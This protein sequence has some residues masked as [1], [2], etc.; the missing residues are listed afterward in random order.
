[1]ASA[2]DQDLLE[3]YD[4]DDD[5]LDYDADSF[6]IDPNVKADP[7]A[8]YDEFD[9]DEGLDDLEKDLLDNS[10]ESPH[11]DDSDRPYPSPSKDPS[12]KH[13]SS[14]TNGDNVDNKSLTSVKNQPDNEGSTSTAEGSS[15]LQQSSFNRQTNT[16]TGRSPFTNS[17]GSGT[18]G[19][20]GYTQGQRGGYLGMN[21]GGGG[22]GNSGGIN[23][24]RGNFQGGGMGNMP[25]MGNMGR[26]G[27]GMGMGMGMNMN[28]NMTPA[29]LQN[30]GM[31]MGM[32]M[33]NM[34]MAMMNMSGMG[35]GRGNQFSAGGFSNQ[36]GM[37]MFGQGQGMNN[38]QGGRGSPGSVGA[39]GR[40]IHINPNFQKNLAAASGTNGAAQSQQF[41]NQQQQQFQ[42]HG[43]GRGTTQNWSQNQKQGNSMNSSAGRS[44]FGRSNGG[45]SSDRDG[46]N[47]DRDQDGS[48]YISDN[49][50]GSDAG[51]RGASV[52]LDRPLGSR[53]SRSPS[54]SITS[55]LSLGTK[56]ANDGPEESH[57]ALKSS[58]GS[59]PRGEQNQQQAVDSSPENGSVSFLREKRFA[60][61][62]DERAKNSNTNNGH[63]NVKVEPKGHV[64]MENIPESVS[65]DSL[66]KLANGIPGVDRVLT[67]TRKGDRA[68]VLGFASVEEA[69]FFRRQINRT[70]IEGSLVT[71]TLA[72]A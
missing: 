45:P 12:A 71:V 33:N 69:K 60:T 9:L 39:M 49:R 4:G 50:R 19:R 66:R 18:N 37:G 46:Y 10:N 53:R 57:K 2:K 72:S 20:G 67:I 42:G 58:G 15:S 55:R 52:N 22:R 1:M 43:Q 63:S 35:M 44:G 21:G 6:E 47:S 62:R 68:V 25:T 16:T 14:P 26:G 24:G 5:L 27:M 61:D 32:N 41:P 40:N 64:K 56:R 29:M 28:M 70:T 34:N 17:R 36:G 48:G 31:G 11:G 54:A 7:A 65:D 13:T 51:G 8:T 3:L 30:M 38:R 59:T 23:M